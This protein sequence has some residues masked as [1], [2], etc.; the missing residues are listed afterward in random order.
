MI[1]LPS[2]EIGSDN[3]RVQR[4]V[5]PDIIRIVA[6]FSVIVLH[7]SGAGFGGRFHY[8]SSE[9]LACNF[10]NGLVRFCVPVFVMISGMFLLNPNHDYPLKK[11]SKKILHIA[12]AF[13][14]WSIVYAIIELLH[15]QSYIELNIK[16]IKFLLI[17]IIQGHYHLWFLF[18]I[19]GLY[20]ITPI[21][22]QIVINERILKYYIFC[23]F[24][25][26]FFFNP[27]TKIPRIGNLFNDLLLKKLDI[28]IVCGFS[29]YYVL[30]YW[31]SI[32]KLDMR[33]RI[34]IYIL[35]LISLLFT[36]IANG[37]ICYRYQEEK[38]FVFDNFLP[39]IFFVSIAIFVF[40]QYAY[41]NME[42]SP[43]IHMTISKIGE[44]C[45]GIYLVHE[46]FRRHLYLIGLPSFFIHPLFSIP[47]SSIIAFILSL[48]FVYIISKIPYIKKYEI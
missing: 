47:I 21:L 38:C 48:L 25:F 45:F 2:H 26:V 9:F 18:M 13:L 5:W 37:I 28:H 29:I 36:V 42:I 46:L 14:I 23:G 33:K 19:S 30:G 4:K 32:C 3:Y 12:I 35:G 22:R 15:K 6:I 10:Y 11:L 44:L 7:S 43:K 40:L 31:L 39:N 8:D 1:N 41:K 20:I 16:T 27:L 24:L 34:Y 17:R